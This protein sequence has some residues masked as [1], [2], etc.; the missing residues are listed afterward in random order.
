MN[1]KSENLLKNC[2]IQRRDRNAAAGC[3]APRTVCPDWAEVKNGKY[4]SIIS[5]I[6]NGG[7]RIGCGVCKFVYGNAAYRGDYH[8]VGTVVFFDTNGDYRQRITKT[9]G[10]NNG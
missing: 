2:R 7:F 1:A 3:K 4:W 6:V 10:I 9:G 8:Y 5:W